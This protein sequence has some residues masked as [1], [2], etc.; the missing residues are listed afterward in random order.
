[1][2]LETGST[3][4]GAD[5]FASQ[6]LPASSQEPVEASQVF[7]LPAIVPYPAN[8]VGGTSIVVQALLA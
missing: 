3:I 4:E 5:V 2:P 1:M 8:L 7:M 6:V